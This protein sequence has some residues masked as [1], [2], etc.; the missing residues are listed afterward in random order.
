[1]RPAARAG[2]ALTGAAIALVHG[3]LAARSAVRDSQRLAMHARTTRPWAL[4]AAIPAHARDVDVV[5][6]SASDFATAAH[7]PW[8]RLQAGREPPRSYRRLSGALQAHDLERIDAHTLEL[9]VLASDLT[10][11]FAGSLYR[12]ADDA[13]HPGDRV[14]LPGLDV[15]VLATDHGNPWRMRFRFERELEDP[16][17]VF[18]EARPEGLRRLALPPIGQSVRLPRA[19]LPWQ[20]AR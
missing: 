4:A 10:D 12:A 7:I 11:S 13:L 6:I 5:L 14:H 17:L 15:E 20:A 2:W 9:R 16:K 8:V 18:L 19:A 3:G 1:V